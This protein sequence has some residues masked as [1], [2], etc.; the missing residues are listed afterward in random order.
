VNGAAHRG[1]RLIDPS[2]AGVIS[3]CEL[4]N[5]W[6]EQTCDHC[7]ERCVN[8]CAIFRPKD[9]DFIYR[10]MDLPFS[11]WEFPNL[12]MLKHTQTKV[13]SKCSRIHWWA[14]V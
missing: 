3:N 8:H 5:L 10:K 12:L 11:K 7:K 13:I 14:L 1:Q 2:E 9:K 4:P 6:V